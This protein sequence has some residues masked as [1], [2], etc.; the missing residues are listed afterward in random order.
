M[1]FVF[2]CP[3]QESAFFSEDFTIIQNRGIAVDPSGDRFLDARVKLTAPCPL[4]GQYH[5]YAAR[6]LA[7]PFLPE[8]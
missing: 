6:D 8:R 1:R 2:T 4:C 7:C 5:E 3:R